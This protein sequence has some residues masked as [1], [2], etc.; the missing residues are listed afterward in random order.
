MTLPFSTVGYQALLDRLAGAGYRAM[1]FSELPG[2]ASSVPRCL[3]RHDVDAN[4]G[5]A[6]RLAEVESERKIRSTYFVMLRSSLYNV[7]GRQGFDDVRRIVALGHE[8]GLHF[9]ASHPA[10]AS[11]ASLEQQVAEEM[12]LLSTVAGARVAAYSFHQPSTDV[13]ARQVSVPGAVNAYA[14]GD[15]FHYISDSNRDW[16]GQDLLALIEQRKP[17]QILL[18]PMWWVCSEPHT[19]D[20]WDAALVDNFSRQQDRLQATERAYG[21][22]RQLRLTRDGTS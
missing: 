16:R 13:L 6:V 5:F 20:C 4:T 2:Q 10:A 17:L 9:D 12:R 22:R 11:A 14:I 7:F 8:I 15:D 21:P 19:W 1:T 3:L 18:H